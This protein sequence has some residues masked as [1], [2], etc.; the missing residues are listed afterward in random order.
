M[1]SSHYVVLSVSS[2]F[3]EEDVVTVRTH[4][5]QLCDWLGVQKPQLVAKVTI[6]RTA[7]QK[8]WC[9]WMDELI[10]V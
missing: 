10:N 2:G 6:L 8:C 3:R 7:N 9:V 1:L 5:N 4:R